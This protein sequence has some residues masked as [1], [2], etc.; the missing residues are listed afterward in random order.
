MR[1]YHPLQVTQIFYLGVLV[2]M[3]TALLTVIILAT[4]PKPFSAGLR[5]GPGRGM[6]VDADCV[7]LLEYRLNMS[8][9][10]FVAYASQDAISTISFY[11]KYF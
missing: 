4:L 11:K 3:A 1:N 10:Y 9:M 8:S 5:I 7:L 6:Y 2:L